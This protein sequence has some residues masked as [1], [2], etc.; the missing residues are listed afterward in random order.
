MFALEV[1][2]ELDAWPEQENHDRKWVSMTEFVA[3]ILYYALT[4]HIQVLVFPNGD[5][6]NFEA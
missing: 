6:R 4:N 5:S 1:T 2:E 3:D